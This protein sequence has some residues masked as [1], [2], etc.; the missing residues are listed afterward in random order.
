MYEWAKREAHARG[1][2]RGFRL[3]VEKEN[4]NAQAVYEK[5]GMRETVYKMFEEML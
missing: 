2:V 5:L 3:Y 4:R 1:D